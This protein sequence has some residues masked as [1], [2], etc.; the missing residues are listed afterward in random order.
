MKI[1]AA[2]RDAF[3][4]YAGHFG[5]T[6]KFLVV[7]GCMTLA[8]LTPLLFLTDEKLK[9]FALL[10]IPFWLLL[11][12]WARVN[13]AA[14]MRDAFGG[15]SLF[16]YRLI[17]PGHYGKKLAYGLK[18]GLMLLFWGAPLFAALYIAWKNYYGYGDTDFITLMR[19][20]KTFGGNDMA[21]GILYLVLVF[22][23]TLLLLAFGCAFHSG[24]RH[25]FVRGNPKLVRK[26]HGKIILC[27]LCSLMALVPL[28]VAI[29]FAVF[30]LLP[31]VRD[32]T[33]YV[34]TK[35][36]AMPSMKPILIALAAGAVLTV[37]LLPL[38]SLIPAAYVNGLEKE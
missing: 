20:I 27:W 9:L 15:G 1:S 14:A 30:Y 23:G 36:K 19:N 10:T 3:R 33:A 25:A 17:E 8:A 7:E 21:T 26:H 31:V 11:M 28:I 34:M 16:T 4:I 5:T 32:V 38:R 24:D 6:L 37:P 35:E 2:I 22:L 29:A 13:A 12:L 18:R